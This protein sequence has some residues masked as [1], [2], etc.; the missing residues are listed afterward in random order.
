MSFAARLILLPVFIHV[1]IVFALL[2]TN[3]RLRVRAARAREVRL[4][5]VA[6]DSRNWPEASRKIGNNYDN[7]FQLPLMW[8][9]LTAL[10]LA[11]GLADMAFAVLAW[12]FLIARIAHALIHTGTN[13]M[14][15]RF[16][17][18]GGGAVILLVMWIWF[19]LRVFAF[20]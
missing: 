7:Q 9:A 14:T 5:D 6:L 11:L 15:Q 8:Y 3:A 1:L 2:I 18:F 19:G 17:V 12:A 13:N 20:G 10:I 4:K 16:F